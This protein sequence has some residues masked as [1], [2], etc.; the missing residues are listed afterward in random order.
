MMLTLIG[1]TVAT[2]SVAY[3]STTVYLNIKHSTRL[4]WLA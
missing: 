1:K 3:A 4:E 2:T